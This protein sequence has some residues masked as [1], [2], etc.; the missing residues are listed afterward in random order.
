MPSSWVAGRPAEL[1]VEIRH[2]PT[3]FGMGGFNVGVLGPPEDDP[4][5][6]AE[7]A[8]AGADLSVVI[9]G[10]ND[11]WECEGWDRPR[12]PSPA[13][14]TSWSRRVAAAGRRT[15]VVVNA[16]SPVLMP[17]LADVDAALLCWFPGPGDGRGPGRRAAG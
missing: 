2:H 17:W 16:G 9:V 15:I 6:S 5:G 11:D 7:A 4:I 8:A 10:T 14:R 12:W 3:G 13:T 1:V